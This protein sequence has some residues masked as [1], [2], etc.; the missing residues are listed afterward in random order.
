[1]SLLKALNSVVDTYKI[2]I[3]QIKDFI[4]SIEKSIDR[5]TPKNPRKNLT[6]EE[7]KQLHNVIDF[8]VGIKDKNIFEP[9][10]IPVSKSVSR[11]LGQAFLT[12]KRKEFLFNM[13]LSFLISHKEAFIKD[14]IFQI[15]THHKNMLKSNARISYEEVLKL[16]SIKALTNEL[17]QRE[18]DAIGYGSIDDVCK[19]FESKF[20]IDLKEFN[21]WEKLREANYRRN[22]IIHNK[23]KTN[24]I[25]CQKIGYKTINRVLPT[26]AEYI[27]DISSILIKFINFIHSKATVR[28]KLKSNTRLKKDGQ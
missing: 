3:N 9:M 13:A 2:E 10:T 19:Y 7:T 28:L 18:V 11:L 1:M 23:G 22:I 21:D 15:L 26:N 8:F 16:S 27:H 12:I 25:Y 6:D 20:N 17:A 14:Y 4:E 5:K 24:E